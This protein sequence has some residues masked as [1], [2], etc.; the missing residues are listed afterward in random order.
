MMFSRS[1]PY[2]T[3]HTLRRDYAFRTIQLALLYERGLLSK[4]ERQ[5]VS[6]PF[7]RLKHRKWGWL[8]DPNEGRYREGNAPLGMDFENY[9]I[10][11]LVPSRLLKNYS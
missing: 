4:L 6:L 9:T 5:F 3:T 2:P 1:A 8:K 7:T 11:G 10:G